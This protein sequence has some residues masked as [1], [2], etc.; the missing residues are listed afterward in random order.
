MYP[1]NNSVIWWFFHLDIPIK[2][3]YLSSISILIP[4]GRFFDTI[5]WCSYHAFTCTP[6]QHWL[7]PVLYSWFRLNTSCTFCSLKNAL[8]VYTCRLAFI[9][10]TG[11][12]LGSKPS[13]QIRYLID[14]DT[15]S[16]HPIVL[17]STGFM[18]W[19]LSCVSNLGGLMNLIVHLSLSQVE[20]LESS[21][22]SPGQTP[23]ELAK[24]WVW[25]L[26][27]NVTQVFSRLKFT[28]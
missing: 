5:F 9:Q 7:L 15:T 1:N 11:Y 17:V 26:I 10:W 13:L 6:V 27:H 18:L 25:E 8:F 22:K 2:Y 23:S 19:T 4:T 12:P 21:V 28:S 14:V 16:T 3:Q 24:R 20:I